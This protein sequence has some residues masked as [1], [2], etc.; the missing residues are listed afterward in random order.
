MAQY[1]EQNAKRQEVKDIA[2]DI[3]TAQDAEIAQMKQWQ[4]DWGY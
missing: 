4:Q 2:S 1:A 3:M